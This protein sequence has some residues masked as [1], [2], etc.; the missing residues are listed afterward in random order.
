MLGTSKSHPA[1]IVSI[2]IVNKM[3]YSSILLIEEIESIII[4]TKMIV[5]TWRISKNKD[6]PAQSKLWTV[7]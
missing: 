3:I 1:L 7:F 2:I 4:E 6:C 5:M